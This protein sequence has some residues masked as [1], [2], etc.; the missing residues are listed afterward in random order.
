[1]FVGDEITELTE[2]KECEEQ[3]LYLYVYITTT[4]D[5]VITIA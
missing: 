2:W 1:M 3:L 4:N 5:N